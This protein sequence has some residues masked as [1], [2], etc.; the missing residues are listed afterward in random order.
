MRTGIKVPV[1][2]LSVMI[3]VVLLGVSKSPALHELFK[4]MDKNADGII[5][6]DEMSGDMKEHAFE[7]IDTDKNRAIS[8]EEWR[9]MADV[10]HRKELGDIFRRIDRDRDR[11][12]TFFEFSDY[13]EKNSN[14]YEAFMGLD[15]DGSNS[16][17]PDEITVRPL[18]RM[19]NM[20]F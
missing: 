3:I 12:I 16:L 20:K 7:G 18:F 4:E 11:R 5:D 14:I 2:I 1:I 6:R 10:Q 19:L 8:E 9:R 15:K 17:S 13:A